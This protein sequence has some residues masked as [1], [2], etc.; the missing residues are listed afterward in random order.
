MLISA[1][2]AATTMT[3]AAAVVVERVTTK[4]TR[5]D[6]MNVIKINDH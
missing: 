2:I 5:S 6:T 4:Y 1:I 3:T